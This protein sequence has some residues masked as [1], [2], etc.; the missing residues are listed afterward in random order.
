MLL[1]ILGFCLHFVIWQPCKQIGLTRNI[2]YAVRSSF[3]L[4]SSTTLGLLISGSVVENENIKG[5][6]GEKNIKK[7]NNV[8]Y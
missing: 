1:S 5:L 8:Y 7:K 6:K 4:G 2:E 3:N